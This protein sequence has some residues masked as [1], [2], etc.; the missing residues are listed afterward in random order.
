MPD[1]MNKASWA[2]RVDLDQGGL[3]PPSEKIEGDLKI[4]T[5]YKEVEGK[6]CKIIR[7]YKMEK[8]QVSKAVA[9]RKSFAKFGDSKNDP[10]GPNP[11]TTMV[12]EEI[13]MQ[14]ITL[15]G[16]IEEPQET[17][18]DLQQ[19]AKQQLK[20]I[21]CRICKEDHWTTQCPYKDRMPSGVGQLDESSRAAAAAANAA[22][23][24]MDPNKTDLYVAPSLRAGAGARRG[25]TMGNTRHGRDDNTVRVTNLSEDIRERDIQ[26]LFSPF[27][28]IQRIYLAKDKFTSNS[29]GFAFVSFVRKEAAVSAIMHLN[30][31]GYDN[32]ILSVEMA[33]KPNT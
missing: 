6:K 21:Q 31:Y 13:F 28:T 30:G 15:K 11:A 4:I 9:H 2:D 32:L 22:S 12:A 8:K 1:A 23:K 5:D 24:G 20:S 29:K 27:G 17:E 18:E 33:N 16:G 26:E 10:S 7:T 14:F 3:P 25:E 19:Q